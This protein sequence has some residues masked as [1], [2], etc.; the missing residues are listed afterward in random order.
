MFIRLQRMT[1]STLSKGGKVISTKAQS[2][3]YTSNW[4]ILS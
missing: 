1:A 2:F 3:W 4:G